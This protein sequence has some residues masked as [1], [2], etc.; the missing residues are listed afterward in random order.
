L[1]LFRPGSGGDGDCQFAIPGLCPERHETRV[2]V[3]TRPNGAGG[4][5]ALACQSLDDFGFSHSKAEADN[6]GA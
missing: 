5:N 2:V 1:D 6:I 4:G 3:A